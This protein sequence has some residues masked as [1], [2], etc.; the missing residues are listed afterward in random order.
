[1]LNRKER[2]YP[3]IKILYCVFFGS[4]EVQSNLIRHWNFID[5][6]PYT[7]TYINIS[8]FINAVLISVDTNAY[9]R[10]YIFENITHS[11]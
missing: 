10:K 1:M 6:I 5:G 7:H 2:I 3:A 4:L 11:L 8:N 9:V